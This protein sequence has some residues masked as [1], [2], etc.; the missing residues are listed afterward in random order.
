[1]LF[2]KYKL[3]FNSLIQYGNAQMTC[4]KFAENRSSTS[5]VQQAAPKEPA[6]FKF[7]G[8]DASA[9]ERAAKAM[10]EMDKSS[11]S[12]GENESGRNCFEKILKICILKFQNL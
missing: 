12:F 1:M 8:F 10:K 6:Q 5:R 7:S 3:E 11:K 2:R 4:S 9:Y